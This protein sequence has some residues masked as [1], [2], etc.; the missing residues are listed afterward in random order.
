[1]DAFIADH[2]GDD[3]AQLALQRRR[4]SSLSDDEFRWALQQIE[5][6]Q[7]LRDKLPSLVADPDFW[8]PVRLSCEQCSSELTAQYKSNLIKKC[9]LS[10]C[11]SQSE[12]CQLSIINC[13]LVD[14]T[15][16]LGIDTL[17]LSRCFTHT[18]YVER[19]PEL[20][21]LALHNLAPHGIT[22]HNTTAEEYLSTNYQ[23][24][25]TNHLYF[26][27]PA[28]RDAHG[29]KVFRLSEC[30][31]DVTQLFRPFVHSPFAIMLK[32]SPMLDITSAL[33]DLSELFTPWQVHVLSI[34]DEVKEVLL[35]HPAGADN[36]PE[37]DT[38]IIATDLAYGW[39][40]RFTLS[41]ERVAVCPFTFQ[42]G[43]PE[44]SADFW[45]PLHLSPFTFIYEPASAILKAGAFRLIAQ[46]FGLEKL[47]SNTHLYTSDTLVPDFP[48]RIFRI[49]DRD[50]KTE[51][52]ANVLVRNYPLSAEQLRRKL[53][54]ED[55][56]DTYVI[57][58]RINGRPTLIT[59]SRVQ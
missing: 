44:K 8:F 54:L 12:K 50:P 10:Y 4:F 38:P 18:D 56:G 43:F 25:I 17:F 1:M 21:R 48:G 47:D 19:D 9:Q 28:R 53:R 2:L 39:T 6:R 45:G 23:S 11:F 32:L 35:Y 26:V 31:P 59:A 41:E 34:R 5:A 40:F 46:R 55:G 29:G 33:R 16:G 27:D 49:E 14:L 20:C 3:V 51:R 30:T 15:G 13:Q 24:P 58:T 42:W 52:R 22:V 37:A 57:G 36:E 7:R